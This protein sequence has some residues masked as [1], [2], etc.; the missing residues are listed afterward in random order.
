MKTN[1]ITTEISTTELTFKP[2]ESAVSFEINAINYSDRF[3]SFQVEVLAAGTDE[4]LAPNWYI[5]SPEIC[6]KKPPGDST[7]FLVKI[8]DSPLPGFVG[9]MNLTVRVFSIEL[10]EETR[11]LLRLN[12]LEGSGGSWLKINPSCP[13]ISSLPLQQIKIPV[14]V[15][16]PS[17][18]PA[19]AVLKLTGINPTWLIEEQQLIQIPSRFRVDAVFWCQIPDIIQTKSQVQ[20]FTITATITN[21]LSRQITGNLLILPQGIVE[22]RCFPQERRIPNR[23]RFFWRSD[24]V[25]FHIE[26]KNYSNISQIFQLQINCSDKIKYE[27]KTDLSLLIQDKK[28]P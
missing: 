3:A 4:N 10:Q 16:N 21:G 7:Q 11:Q 17:S 26:I 28:N 12:I 20:P 22:F 6:T 19:N 27:L 2:G 8:I 13:G 14:Q 15:Y 23:R 5:L 9:Q 1:L 25:I 24:P 18:Q